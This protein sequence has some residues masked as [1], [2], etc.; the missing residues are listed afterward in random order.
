MI[1]TAPIQNRGDTLS[2]QT[3]IGFFPDGELIPPPP[4]S[5]VEGPQPPLLILL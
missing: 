2:R 4:P 3:V 1:A 5:G